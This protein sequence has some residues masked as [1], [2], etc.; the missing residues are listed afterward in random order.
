M[1]KKFQLQRTLINATCSIMTLKRCPCSS[2]AELKVPSPSTNANNCRVCNSQI[3]T[4]INNRSSK[5]T[6][7]RYPRSPRSLSPPTTLPS[8]LL[9][10]SESQRVSTITP[11]ARLERRRITKKRKISLSNPA[12]VRVTI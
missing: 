12:S 3:T 7:S 6:S 9:G 5:L 2:L 8:Y 11:I 10:S 1:R 4:M